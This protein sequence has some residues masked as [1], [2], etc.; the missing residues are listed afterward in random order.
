MTPQEFKRYFASMTVKMQ[1]AVQGGDLAK[2][3]AN[4]A[5]RLFRQNFREESFFGQKWD[6]V[7]RRK[8]HEVEYRTPGGKVKTKTVPRGKGVMGSRK[9]LTGA[10]GNLGRSIRI[11]VSGSSA[12][13]YSDLPYSAAHNDGTNNAGR[14]HNTRIPQRKFIGEHPTVTAAMK[15]KI[16]EYSNKIIAK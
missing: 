8:P 2:V 13:V 3:A 14:G 6:E 12:V 10:T 7:Q 11:Q 9:I 15:A 4:E 16:E 5:A 1:K